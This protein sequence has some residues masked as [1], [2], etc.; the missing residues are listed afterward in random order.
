VNSV[1]LQLALSAALEAAGAASTLLLRYFGALGETRIKAKT[2]AVDLVSNADV[3]AE[4]A[5][6]EILARRLPQAGF[7]GEES[8]AQAGA[9]ADLNWVVDPLDG[10]S[11]FLSGVPLWSVSIALADARLQPLAGVVAAP[12]LGKTWSAYQ[13]GG[14]RLNGAPCAVRQEPPGGGLHNAMLATGFPYQVTGGAA[15]TNLANFDH[16]QRRF[17][18]IRRLG[19]AAIDLAFICEGTFDGMWE[20]MLQPWDSAAGILLVTEAGGCI[21]RIDGSLFTPGNPDLL[22]AA[23]PELL[24]VLQREL[25][26]VLTRAG[27]VD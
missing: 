11:N 6:R 14:T 13:G 10:T 21:S 9:N 12:V 4:Q 15:D 1:D 18:K 8:P 19:S 2:S 20:L 16:M 22:A 24:E 17:H 5:I 23:T 7:I 27:E 25:A 26:S 3:E